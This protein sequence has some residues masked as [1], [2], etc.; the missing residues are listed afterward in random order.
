[1]LPK[2]RMAV[3]RYSE[4]PVDLPSLDLYIK[5]TTMALDLISHVLQL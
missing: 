3:P 1:M 4:V 2:T 5:F